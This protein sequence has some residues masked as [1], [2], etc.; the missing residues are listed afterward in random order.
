MIAELSM[1]VFLKPGVLDYDLESAVDS[2]FYIGPSPRG[3]EKE[4][5]NDRRGENVQTTP[6]RTY[7]KRSRPWTYCNPYQKDAPALEVYPAPLHHPTTQYHDV[8]SSLS[9]YGFSG[10]CL[11]ALVLFQ[12]QNNELGLRPNPPDSVTNN[13]LT[14]WLEK[15]SIKI[16]KK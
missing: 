8:E 1:K 7:C 12:L 16:N 3:R 10:V 6:T 11:P 4:E 9:Q 13:I 5:R 2:I 15:Y 14:E